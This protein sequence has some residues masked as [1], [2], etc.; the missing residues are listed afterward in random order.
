MKFDKVNI[1]SLIIYSCDEKKNCVKYLVIY[2]TYSQAKKK[3]NT[4]SKEM[5]VS[6]V[7]F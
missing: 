4:T 5:T 2:V 3:K 7:F 1:F 6:N